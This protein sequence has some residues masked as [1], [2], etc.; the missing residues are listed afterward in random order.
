MTGQENG[1]LTG[2]TNGP[3]ELGAVGGR[4]RP[5]AVAFRRIST[6]SQALSFPSGIW[7]SDSLGQTETLA[8]PTPRLKRFDARLTGVFSSLALQCAHTIHPGHPI[9]KRTSKRT[10]RQAI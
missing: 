3:W 5:A 8:A 9:W 1:T 4:L 6:V 2:Q 7:E 10:C